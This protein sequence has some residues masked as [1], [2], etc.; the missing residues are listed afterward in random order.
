MIP[1]R[2][3]KHGQRLTIFI[4]TRVT[5]DSTDVRE[6]SKTSLD[7]NVPKSEESREIESNNTLTLD[8]K[9]NRIA[10]VTPPSG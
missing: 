3:T 1:K 5:T 9:A 4:N 10:Y 7:G 6:Q 8:N 2:R